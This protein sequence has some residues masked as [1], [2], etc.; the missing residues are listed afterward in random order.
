MS[1]SASFFDDFVEPLAPDPHEIA[2][3][4][5]AYFD[6]S[7]DD[8][9]L[10]VAGYVFTNRN[11]RLLDGEW[12]KMLA[13]Y[14]RLP[15]FRMSACNARQSPFDRLTDFECIRVATEA[16]ALINRYAEFGCA[17]TVDPKAFNKIVT[18]KG[19]VGSPYEYCSWLCLISARK[20]SFAKHK[21]KSMSF[22]FEAGF[23]D[24]GRADTMM[25]RIFSLPQHR[26]FYNYKSHVFIDKAECGPIQAADL[27]AWQWYKDATRRANGAT[28]SRGDL[29]ALMKGT[30]HY[31]MHSNAER[32]QDTVDRINARAGSPLGNVI[33][34]VALNNPSSPLFPKKSGEDGSVEAFEELKKQNPSVM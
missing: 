15:F 13:R 14:K 20:E 30:S 7:Y 32:L 1:E 34:G 29:M 31:A 10:C 16:I 23:K 17:I 24:H 33:A 22:F 21:N 8:N 11:A 25:S 12:K 27:L 3:F 19:A 6:E 26:S 18:K 28:K 4:L 9:L 5:K 2:V